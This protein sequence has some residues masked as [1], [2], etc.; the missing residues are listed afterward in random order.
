MEIFDSLTDLPRFIQVPSESALDGFQVLFQSDGKLLEF[1]PGV[2]VC[3]LG[4]GVG[5]VARKQKS[6]PKLL[7]AIHW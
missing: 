1:S 7:I 3:V 6:L 5:I 4:V 2:C